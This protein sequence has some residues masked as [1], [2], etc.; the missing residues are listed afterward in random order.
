MSKLTPKLPEEVKQRLFAAAL[1]R[2][3]RDQLNSI[4]DGSEVRRIAARLFEN[5]ESVRARLRQAGFELTRSSSGS[6]G[7]WRPKSQSSHTENLED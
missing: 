5:P 3:K 6:R 2:H 1:R 7:V 4:Y